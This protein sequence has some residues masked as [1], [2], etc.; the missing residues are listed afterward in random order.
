MPVF[1]IIINMKCLHV[2][3]QNLTINHTVQQ[4]KVSVFFS[5]AVRRFVT[6]L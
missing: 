1:R 2:F 4:S 3:K 6:E 5:I